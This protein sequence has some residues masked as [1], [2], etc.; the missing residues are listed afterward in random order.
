MVTRW[1]EH[2]GEA[3]VGRVRETLG[4][5][6]ALDTEVR[7]VL[8]REG[9]DEGFPD[10]A[11]EEAA[12]LPDAVLP[13]EIEGRDDLRGLDRATL[14]MPDLSLLEGRWDATAFDSR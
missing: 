4:A 9:V 8:L 13:A 6:G 12:A 14:A 1:P 10:D 5:P 3:P 2:P 11:N 7:K